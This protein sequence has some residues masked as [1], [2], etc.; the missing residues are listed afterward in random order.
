MDRR[1]LEVFISD[2]QLRSNG[3]NGKALATARRIFGFGKWEMY[4]ARRMFY[5]AN[6]RGKKDFRGTLNDGS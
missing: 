1:A 5:G 2:L 4:L 3:C 6:A